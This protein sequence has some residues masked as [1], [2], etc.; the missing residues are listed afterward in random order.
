MSLSDQSTS[1]VKVLKL[2]ICNLSIL[3]LL[4]KSKL[5][6]NPVGSSV[7][8]T[9]AL[10]RVSSRGKYKSLNY[11]LS[12]DFTFC[13]EKTFLLIE[14]LFVNHYNSG[15]KEALIGVLVPLRS[16][17]RFLKLKLFKESPSHRG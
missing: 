4:S 13:P 6:I 12:L 9:K 3:T 1:V 17:T 7:I 11:N 8:D 10:A 14:R 5:P 2:L 16:A 15:E